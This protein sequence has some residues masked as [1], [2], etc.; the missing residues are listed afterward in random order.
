MPGRLRAAVRPRG[1][2]QPD[3]GLGGRRDSPG[4]QLLSP[5]PSH[6]EDGVFKAG[7]GLGR[8]RRSRESGQPGGWDRSSPGRSVPP[9]AGRAGLRVPARE[10]FWVRSLSASPHR[11][12]VVRDGQGRSLR[13]EAPRSRDKASG[14]L[15]PPASD[16]MERR[17]PEK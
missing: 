10:G 8:G 14:P 1:P 4:F 13:R 2:G 17:T 16:E 3:A 12:A 5:P 15:P 11:R 7:P 6:C 9:A